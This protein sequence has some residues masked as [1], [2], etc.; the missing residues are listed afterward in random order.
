[1]ATAAYEQ[2]L[3]VQD[4]D[5][6]LT[7]LRHRLANHPLRAELASAE[8]ERSAIA[9]SRDAIEERRHELDRDLRR[10]ADE[11]AT[12]EERRARTEARLYDG[13]V[14]ATKE[15]LA[16]QDEARSLLDRQRHLEDGELELME[17]LETVGAEAD[18]VNAELAAVDGRL[19]ELAAALSQATTEI[20]AEL[21]EVTAARDTAVQPVGAELLARYLSLAPEFDGVPLARFVAGRC[22]GC[23]MQLSAMAVDRLNK[24]PPDEPVTCE[25]CGRLLVR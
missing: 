23:H 2:L 12:I 25:E 16:L 17:S 9:G 20:E 6:A 7:Q 21:A 4:L 15:L 22:D 5:L 8:E 14:T 10:L 13:S 18:G 1:M 3:A 19:S 11:V 24:T